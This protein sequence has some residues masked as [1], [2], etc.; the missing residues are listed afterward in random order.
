MAIQLPELKRNM[1]APTPASAGRIDAKMPDTSNETAQMTEGLTRLGNT[2]F[3]IA[4]KYELNAADDEKLKAKIAYSDWYRRK[5]EGDSKTGEMGLQHLS[6]DPTEAYNAF[7]KEATEKFN[8]ILN[9]P[10]L[11]SRA[12]A[13]V[14]TGLLE[15][16]N[17]LHS[18]RLV[19]YGSQHA[20]YQA[21]LT[22]A[23][24]NLEVEGAVSAMQFADAN[25][26]SSFALFEEKLQ[27]IRKT[28]TNYGLK[29][30]GAVDAPDGDVKHI[31]G[32]GNL[33]HLKMEPVLKDSMKKSFSK[34]TGTSIEVLIDSKKLPEA[35]MM[36]KQYKG[37]LDGA[38]LGKLT[39]AYQKKEVEI[40]ADLHLAKTAG[41]SEGARRAYLNTLPKDTPQQIEIWK[42]TRD[43][44]N[45]DQVKKEASLQRQSKDLGDRLYKDITKMQDAGQTYAS[46][47]DFLKGNNGANSKL[48]DGIKDDQVLKGLRSLL[49]E[50]P[51]VS[52][53]T[54][55]TKMNELYAQKDGIRTKSA[56]EMTILTADLAKSDADVFWNF[57]RASNN[58]T[59]SEE[60]AK[61]SRVV[62][63]ATTQFKAAKLYE[64]KFG[65]VTENSEAH[66]N[67]FLTRMRLNAD[68]LK[69][70]ASEK[71]INEWVA[72]N[73][74]QEVLKV[75]GDGV[76]VKNRFNKWK[77]GDRP[78]FI[79]PKS[80]R[81]VAKPKVKKFE[82]L[83]P[84]GR[85][86]RY[87]E[88]EAKFGQKPSFEDLQKWIPE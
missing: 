40:N 1:E 51:K 16:Y 84:A 5:I 27:G 14:Q 55:L 65:G 58:E 28:V 74:A 46:W 22:D 45:D 34:A 30:N 39:E 68:T 70:G 69:A 61:M 23:A 60:G 64:K 13:G 18:N 52:D 62:N 24:V 63:I 37:Y 44:I 71:E 87:K 33:R 9:S 59:P 49:D 50:R 75:R 19:T 11:S 32:D 29:T 36:M 66:L 20:K 31:D 76:G 57:W 82:E 67:D 41:M 3:N 17:S 7:D 48:V 78:Q 6:G 72:E 86:L 53:Q 80:S 81:S 56:Q 15:A 12:R 21:G 10:N 26:P 79:P 88:Y 77:D 43:E 47:N 4:D 25:D 73:I 85:E 54:A 8:E 38:T 2:A 35:E 42:K 83:D